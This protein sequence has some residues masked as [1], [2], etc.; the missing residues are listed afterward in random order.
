MARSLESKNCISRLTISTA[1][2]VLAFGLVAAPMVVRA[3]VSAQEAEALKST[4]T[5]MGAVRAGNTDGTIPAWM[6]GVSAGQGPYVPGA[7]RPDL[8]AADKP[9]FSITGTN[10]NQYADK[11]PEGAKALFAKFPDY[12]MD[13]YPT[14]RS[15]A[16]P[17][18]V[19]DAIGVNAVRAH[20]SKSGI[21]NGVEGAVGGIP[22]PIPRD[23]FEVMWNHLLAFWGPSRETHLSTY[24]VSTAGQ[25]DLTSAYREVAD[26]PYYY[27]GATPNSFGRYYFKTRHIEDAPASKAGEGYLAW[28][29]IDIDRD[30]FA[31]WR[32]VPG[33][34]RARRGPSLSYDT[35]DPSASGFQTLDEYYLFF[36]GL[37]RYDWKLLEKREMYVPYNNNRLYTLPISDVLAPGHTKPDALRYELHRVWVVEGTLAKGKSHIVPRRRIYIDEDT[38]FAVYSDS[39]DEEGRLWKFGHGTMYVMQDVPAV[40]LGSQFIYDLVLGG[41]VYGFAFNGDPLQYKV[42]A[43]HPA[44]MLT[45]EALA[46]Q[47]R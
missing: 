45:P 37:D 24:V 19:Y 17:Q 23:G 18:S 38:W 32:Y 10:L 5:P 34:G 22:F 42:T 39:W 13:I 21:A 26:F 33:E 40:I 4:L 28:Q 27:P 46:S 41:Y 16:A 20:A 31:A 43:P 8:F 9:L 29:P 7:I 6:G 35:P 1:G 44:S 30:K 3:G 2:F 12:R 14:R 25:I 11:L 15:A 36:G 47:G